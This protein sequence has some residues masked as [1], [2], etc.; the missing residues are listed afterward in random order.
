MT[1]VTLRFLR[2][3]STSSAEDDVLRVSDDSDGLYRVS[4]QALG[5][6]KASVFYLNRDDTLDYISTILK[7]LTYDTAPF[8][9]LQVDT[10]LHPSVLYHVSD[11]DNRDARSLVLDTISDTLRTE[12]EEW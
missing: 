5:M 4:F 7:T 10:I 2:S 6:K 8:H 3:G 12:V 11:L 1:K 9:E